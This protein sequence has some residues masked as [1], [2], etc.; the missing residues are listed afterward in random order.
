MGK[1]KDKGISLN[2]G[3]DVEK[4]R[5]FKGSINW[6]FDASLESL[7]LDGLFQT[8]E[9]KVKKKESMKLKPKEIDLGKKK[10]SK[11]NELI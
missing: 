2:G 5:L 9:V 4:K 7:S 6:T 1:Y 3:D 10:K 8:N 11:G